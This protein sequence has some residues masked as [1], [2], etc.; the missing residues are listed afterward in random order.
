MNPPESRKALVNVACLW[1]AT[2]ALEF[3]LAGEAYCRHGNVRS[4]VLHLL[5]AACAV[6]LRGLYAER[7]ARP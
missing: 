3:C 5:V 2:A 1:T 6:R 7:A 4:A